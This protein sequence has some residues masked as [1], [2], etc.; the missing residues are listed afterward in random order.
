MD[1]LAPKSTAPV[2]TT[3]SE[4]IVPANLPAPG[5]APASD[6]LPALGPGPA[7]AAM[8]T[9]DELQRLLKIYMGAKKLSNDEPRSTLKARFLDLYSRK[10][11][12]NCYQFYQ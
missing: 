8:Y 1:L 11:Y 7:P 10:L 3:A 2:N 9:E 4:P 5:A 6:S 12:L